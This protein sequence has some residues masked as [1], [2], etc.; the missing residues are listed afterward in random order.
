MLVITASKSAASS[1]TS[2]APRASVPITAVSDL[3]S[4]GDVYPQHVSYL[5]APGTPLEDTADIVRALYGRFPRLRGPTRANSPTKRQIV[6]K[7][8]ARWPPPA[9]FYSS[10]DCTPLVPDRNWTTGWHAPAAQPTT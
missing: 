3:N 4:L 6:V 9:T 2:Y 10:V 5:V 1:V 8:C 7:R